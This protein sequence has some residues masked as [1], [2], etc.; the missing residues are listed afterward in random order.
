MPLKLVQV[1]AFADRMFSGN[2]AAVCL[3][4][5]PRDA[6]WMQSVAI[7]MN[8]SET[9]FLE[10]RGDEWGLRWF[11]PA[12]EVD[13]C[14]HATL[15]SA[16]V[17]WQDGHLPESATARFHTRSGLLTAQRDG[18]WIS[19]DFPAKP[20][21]PSPAPDGLAE[22]LGAEPVA[23][24]RSHFDFVVE[25]ESEAVVRGLRPD[26]ARLAGV[27]ARGVI[28][29]A[30]GEN[31]EYDFVS[32][33][34]APRVGVPED[35]VT[36]SAHCA[37]APYWAARLGRERMTGYQASARGGVVRVRVEGDRVHLGGQA[38]TVMRG[39]LVD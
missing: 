26:Q 22:A 16:H 39:A 6:A 34:F 10:P 23:I 19:M 15:A 20:S 5:A 1:D 4:D 17:L 14:G 30:R 27:E 12:V 2:P 11:T 32:R 31:G 28:V 24:V 33:F 38:I 35:P 13:L 21:Q 18:E 25:L 29:T 8:L 37:L 3:L 36:G 7:E 9:A